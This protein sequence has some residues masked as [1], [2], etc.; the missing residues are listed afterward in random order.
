MN[1]LQE[2]KYVSKR[3]GTA[4]NCKCGFLHAVQKEMHVLVHLLLSWQV[5]TLYAGVSV[6]L[7]NL[8][9]ENDPVPAFGYPVIK[10]RGQRLQK[11][12]VLVEYDVCLEG[13]VSGKEELGIGEGHY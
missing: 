11:S 2:F 3:I 1:I 13:G 7:E 9:G 4:G 10:S 8:R 6:G 5:H 12:T